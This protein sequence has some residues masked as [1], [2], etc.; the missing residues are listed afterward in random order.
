M[1]IVF[2]SPHS[3]PLALAGEPDSGGQCIYEF[4]LASSLSRIKNTHV[5][6]FCRQN[7]RRP[8]YEEV[9][10]QFEIFRI[11]C[12]PEKFVRKEEI[13]P[14]LKEFSAKVAL[15]LKLFRKSKE[16]VFHGHYWDGAKSLPFMKKLFPRAVCFWTP[17]S[18][19]V[20]KRLNFSDIKGEIKYNFLSR[21]LWESYA[22]LI[23]D[24]I[25]VSTYEEKQVMTDYYLLPASRIEIVTPGVTL[26]KFKVLSQEKMRIKY[27]LPREGKILLCLG[28]ITESK[29]YHHAI[30]A[31]KLLKKKYKEPVLLLICGGSNNN[32]VS[33]EESQYKSYLKK[34]AEKLK[35]ADFV[36][37]H[38]A[39]P[40]DKVHE[41]YSAADILLVTA[42]NEPFGFTVLEAMAMKIPLVSNTGEG[43]STLIMNNQ[44]GC[45]VNIHYIDRFTNYIYALLMDEDYKNKLVKNA[46]RFVS[47]NFDWDNKAEEIV[48]IYSKSFKNSRVRRES[49]KLLNSSDFLNLNL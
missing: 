48:R 13:E 40:H 25:I 42:E 34:Y 7:Y 2:L 38:P 6:I 26:S 31:L 23:C 20:L 15:K 47:T 10:P 43:P 14:Y 46:F 41:I 5:K 44:T 11:N 3:D 17:H 32:D 22:G 12:G 39:V 36:I 33:S 4:E 16:L 35:V 27:N 19:G 1:E 9:N 21:V 37:F 18:L 45:I 28:R 29:G 30:H 8:D 49:L 24:K